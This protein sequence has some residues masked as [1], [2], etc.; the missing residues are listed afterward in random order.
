M[1]FF[2]GRKNRGRGREKV[3]TVVK[4][5]VV[6]M[7]LMDSNL[8]CGDWPLDKQS[9]VEAPESCGEDALANSYQFCASI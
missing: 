4:A 1:G 6:T 7:A 2:S 3:L 8:W 5:A 9:R